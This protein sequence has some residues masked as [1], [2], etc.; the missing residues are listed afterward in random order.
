M[1]CVSELVANSVQHSGCRLVHISVE[2]LTHHRVRIA[3]GDGSRQTVAS[4]KTADDE[5]TGRG[6]L[7][8]QALSSSWGVHDNGPGKVVWAC[9]VAKEGA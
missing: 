3:V 7:I 8:V 2:R 6:L 4:R 9:L 1:L 5:E